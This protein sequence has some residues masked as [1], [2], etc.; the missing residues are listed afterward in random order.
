MPHKAANLTSKSSLAQSSE[1]ERDKPGFHRQTSLMLTAHKTTMTFE[2]LKPVLETA[3][4]AVIMMDEQGIILGWNELA[5]STFG[6]SASEAV[7]RSLSSLIIPKH[8]RAAH[9]EGLRRF[10]AT[11]ETHVLNRRIEITALRKDG[12]EFPV[13]LSIAATGEPGSR[14]FV[15]YLREITARLEA[16]KALRDSEADLRLLLDSTA[17]GFYAVDLDGVTTACNRSFVRMLGFE[18]DADAIGKKLHDTI[19]HSLPDGSHYPKNDCPI[20]RCAQTGEPAH[21]A[22][23][24]FFRSDGSSFPVEYWVHPIVRDG[25]LQ[26]AVCTF[27]D[28]T[29]RVAADAAARNAR[30]DTRYLERQQA[31]ILG[32]LVEGVIVA[33]AAGKLTFV[34][35]AAARLHGV[36]RLDVEPDQYSATYHLFTETGEPYPPNELPLARAVCGETIEEARW[37]VHRPDGTEVLAVGSARP[38]FDKSGVQTGAVLTVRDETARDMAERVVRE[39]EAKLRAL[40]DNLPGGVVYQLSTSADGAE[41]RFLY[42]SQSHEKLTGVS[43][44]AVMADASIPY[45]MVHPEDRVRLAEAEGLAIRNKAPFDMQVRYRRHDGEERWCRLVS[46][47][48]E[49]PD[50]SLVWDGLQ[51]DI[52]DRVAAEI[53]LQELNVNLERRV[54]ERTRERDRAWKNSRDLQVVVSSE[55]VFSAANEAWR[56][57]LGWAPQEVVG[58]HHLEFIHPDD[59]ADSERAKGV[60]TRGELEPYENRC[61]HKDGTY[62]W[63][64]WVAATEDGLIYA[65]GRHISSEK[66]AQEALAS[67]AEQLRQAQ[68][69]EAVGQLTGGIAHDFNNLLAGISGS[70]EAIE[71]RVAE[72]RY[73]DLGRYI[74][75][76]QGAAGRAASLTQRLLAFSRRQTLDPTPTDVNRLIQGMEDLIRRSIGP[77]I[78]LEVVGAGGLWPTL[79]DA[80]Q[81]ENA[82]LNLCINARDAMPDG[83]RITIETANKWLDQREAR[84]RDLPPGQYL[85]LCVTDTGTGMPQEVIDRAF[86]PFFTTK[87]IGQG[88]GLG[89]S[90][91]YGFVRQSDGQ[92]RI[93]SEEGHGTTMCLYLP[94]FAG[95]VVKLEADPTE[96]MAHGDGEIV[97]VIDDEPLIRMLVVEALEENGYRVLDAGDGPSG[98]RLLGS[99][100]HVDLLITDVGLPGGMN[101]RQVADAA[102][103]ARPDLK[104]LFMTG[105]AENAV[106]GNG[107]LDHGMKVLTKP[108]LHTDLVNKVR[109]QIAGA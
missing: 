63:I 44:E 83:G 41:R 93:Y 64:S 9:N 75:G 61:R 96:L 62:R 16:E 18:T 31:A 29:E 26:G 10:L 36:A 55:G 87:P 1:I 95:A 25:A 49:Q 104:V 17:E 69:M 73:H 106:V 77:D 103:V 107:H 15:G 30:S 37:R 51:I 84:N 89:L 35:D 46:A 3:L 33:D 12:E 72:Q 88:T 2:S 45:A 5:V 82:L 76:A 6:R 90:M 56:P 40:A 59:Q 52:S 38:V 108:F 4:D 92:V 100:G 8:Y 23:E 19:H 94:R 91:I 67:T 68:K 70:L 7:G 24:Y 42:V 34:N 99:V 105:Y 80:S 22:D 20:Y 97:V 54:E 39:S 65:S 86:D 102:R 28:V 81:L 47:P 57:I 79:I 98:L 66:E 74:Q 48:R 50:G 53:A 101:G 32:Q 13:E 11:G 109:E 27:L 43:A 60:A 58:R 71:R 21:I 85:S 14:V 78:A